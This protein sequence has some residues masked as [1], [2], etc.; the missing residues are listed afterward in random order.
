[1]KKFTEKTCVSVSVMRTPSLSHQGALGY[2][3]LGTTWTFYFTAIPATRQHRRKAIERNLC[4]ICPDLSLPETS[5]SEQSKN[6]SPNTWSE[7]RCVC[8]KEI[9]S[10]RLSRIK[11]LIF[12]NFSY[13][14]YRELHKCKQ[15]TI[16]I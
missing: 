5:E 9:K 12:S 2:L 16:L 13:S 1:M 15:E 10:S 6:Y 8:L 11:L 4:K 14:N 3:L 7:A